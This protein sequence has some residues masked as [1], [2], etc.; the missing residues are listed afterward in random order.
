MPPHPPAACRCSQLLEADPVCRFRDQLGAVW[1]SAVSA[2]FAVPTDH[3][4]CL[5]REPEAG[6]DDD[7]VIDWVCRRL[8]RHLLDPT[9]LLPAVQATVAANLQRY[10]GY[11]GDVVAEEV[12]NQLYADP[13]PPGTAT[14]I[15]LELATA[16]RPAR[17][18]LAKRAWDNYRRYDRSVGRRDRQA[19]GYDLSRVAALTGEPVGEREIDELMPRL[20]ADQ[21]D[22]LRLFLAGQMPTEIAASLGRSPRWVYLRLEEIRHVIERAGA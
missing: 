2:V 12:T 5:L 19:G 4:D 6:P 1:P 10:G 18:L 13:R 15:V 17:Q 11:A 7:A 21:G 9:R 8:I 22:V 14:R 20:T 16:E 3:T